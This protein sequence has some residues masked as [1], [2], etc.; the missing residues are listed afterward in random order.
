MKK[1]ILGMVFVFATGT[2]MNANSNITLDIINPDEF[3]CA[4]SSWAKADE[5]QADTPNT[6]SDWDMW[7]V[8]NTYYAECMGEAQ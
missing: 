1:L 4:E 8:T 5:L 7:E 2:M 6:L 3:E